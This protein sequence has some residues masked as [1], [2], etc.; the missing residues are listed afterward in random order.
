MKTIRMDIFVIGA[1]VNLR[2]LLK[3]SAREKNIDLVCLGTESALLSLIRKR[4]PA[5]IVLNFGAGSPGL[6]TLKALRSQNSPSP[7]IVLDAPD[8]PV[9]VDRAFVPA[10][11]N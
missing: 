3:L 4:V 1:G 2:K 5:C 11:F 7:T 6:S 9:A 8:L 10:S